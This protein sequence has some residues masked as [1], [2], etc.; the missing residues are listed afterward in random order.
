MSR[1]EALIREK[2]NWIARLTKINNALRAAAD[3]A[4]AGRHM[5]PD[6]FN[7]L[8]NDRKRA[9]REVWRIDAEL[10]KMIPRG[11][12]KY[13]PLEFL[14]VCRARLAPDVFKRL[15][16]EAFANALKRANEEKPKVGA[17]P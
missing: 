7:A 11:L 1:R 12:N 16:D 2:D 15:H 14:S 3:D 10:S 9:A 17:E 8:H 13:L 5:R 4:R 6:Q